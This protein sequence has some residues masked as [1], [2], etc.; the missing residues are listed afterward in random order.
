M[1]EN[2]LIALLHVQLPDVLFMTQ[3]MSSDLNTH[4]IKTERLLC[5]TPSCS[6]LRSL[7]F[8]HKMYL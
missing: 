5:G 6:I 2:I 3:H 4:V 8:F 1:N 7:N